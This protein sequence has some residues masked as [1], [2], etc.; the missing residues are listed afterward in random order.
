MQIRESEHFNVLLLFN[1]PKTAAWPHPRIFDVTS[2]SLSDGR[3]LRKKTKKNKAH[4]DYWTTGTVWS[5]HIIDS[6]C[7]VSRSRLMCAS[8]S[9][10]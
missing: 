2:L 10:I 1:T 8:E 5:I 6:E 3:L 7:F 4:G 9:D